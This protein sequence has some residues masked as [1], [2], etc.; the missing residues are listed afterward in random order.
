[1]MLTNYLNQE[2]LLYYHLDEEKCDNYK[3]SDIKNN[4]HTRDGDK[5]TLMIALELNALW[6]FT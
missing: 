6:L 1:M 5:L 3:V 2:S 4:H